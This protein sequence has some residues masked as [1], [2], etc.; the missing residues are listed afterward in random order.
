MQVLSP[1]Q[2]RNLMEIVKNYDNKY[3]LTNILEFCAVFGIDIKIA[4]KS[5]FSDGLF[6]S[7]IKNLEELINDEIKF[8]RIFDKRKNRFISIKLSDLKKMYMRFVTEILN[9][10]PLSRKLIAESKSEFGKRVNS[11]YVE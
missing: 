7:H 5:I 11:D 9:Q 4:N 6:I 10:L 8:I 1:Q 3:R 2:E